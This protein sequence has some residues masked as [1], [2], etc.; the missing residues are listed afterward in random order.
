MPLFDFRCKA[1]GHIERDVVIG[2]FSSIPET[3]DGLAPC[4]KCGNEMEKCPPTGTSFR[5]GKK[6]ATST[7]GRRSTVSMSR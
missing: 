3:A 2:K 7:P 1:C 5:M 4:P 6:T